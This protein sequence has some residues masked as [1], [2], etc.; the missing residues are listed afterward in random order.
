MHMETFQAFLEC[1]SNFNTIVFAGNNA[2]HE[3]TKPLIVLR[4][5]VN[6]IRDSHSKSIIDVTSSKRIHCIFTKN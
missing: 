3:S 1:S 5:D 6:R 4:G 2:K